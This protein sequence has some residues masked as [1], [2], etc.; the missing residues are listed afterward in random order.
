MLLDNDPFLIKSK[1]FEEVC[2]PSTAWV[3]SYLLFPVQ[4]HDGPPYLAA[5]PLLIWLQL[6]LLFLLYTKQ[7]VLTSPSRLRGNATLHRAFPDRVLLCLIFQSCF[8]GQGVFTC[9]NTAKDILDLKEIIEV[10]SGSFL[11]IAAQIHPLPSCP[12]QPWEVPACQS[13]HG[14]G[15]GMAEEETETPGVSSLFWYIVHGKSWVIPGAFSPW[16][17]HS[18]GSSTKPRL[19]L[20]LLQGEEQLPASVSQGVSRASFSPTTRNHW[21]QLQLSNVF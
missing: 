6:G 7:H 10:S 19:P 17:H 8:W 5:L 4:A 21:T 2:Q 13:G 11:H 9:A 18:L 16:L 15:P 1:I 20:S 14:K 3:H 12:A